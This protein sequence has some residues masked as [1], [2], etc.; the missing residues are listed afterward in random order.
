MASAGGSA[1]KAG[2]RSSLAS[3]PSAVAGSTDKPS[4]P[5]PRHNEP[6]AAALAPAAEGGRQSEKTL[7]ERASKLAEQIAALTVVRAPPPPRARSRRVV[8][9]REPASWAALSL[10]VRSR[11]RRCETNSPSA[12]SR[13]ASRWIW[14]PPTA[15]V[16]NWRRRWPLRARYECGGLLQRS[17]CLTCRFQQLAVSRQVE[18]E[19]LQ[20][21]LWNQDQEAQA[22]CVPS[23]RCCT[24][25]LALTHS[26]SFSS[27]QCRPDRGAGAG[28][29]RDEGSRGRGCG[30]G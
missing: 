25:A 26:I 5:R 24:C 28:A 21:R 11:R 1:G 6:H 15:A 9:R 13:S 19:H 4:V 30:Q 10:H 14:R 29:A 2:G 20:E 8:Q 3:A 18:T 16:P 7:L 27:F 22:Q 23:A 12:R 17:C